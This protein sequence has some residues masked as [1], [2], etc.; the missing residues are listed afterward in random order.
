MFTQVGTECTA[1]YGKVTGVVIFEVTQ[2]GFPPEL[3]VRIFVAFE[4]QENATKVPRDVCSKV[5]T[6][7]LLTLKLDRPEGIRS[8]GDV[9]RCVCPAVHC[10]APFRLQ[11]RSVPRSVDTLSKHSCPVRVSRPPDPS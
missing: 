11:F 5:Y 6:F 1:K 8:E 3:A 4:R 7:Q 9:T 2:P 10:F